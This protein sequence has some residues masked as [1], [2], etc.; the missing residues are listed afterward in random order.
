MWATAVAL[1]GYLGAASYRYLE[2]ELGI[3][4]WALLTVVG[5]AVALRTWRVRRRRPEFGGGERGGRAG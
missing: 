3:G 2:R 1:L 5:L 4:E